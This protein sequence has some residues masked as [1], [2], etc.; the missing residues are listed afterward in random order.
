MPHELL[1]ADEIRRR[2]PMFNVSDEEFGYFE[3]SAGFVRPEACVHAQLELAKKYGAD[4]HMHENGHGLRCRMDGRVTVK[5]DTGSYQA[6][7]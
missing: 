6:E 3:P 1:D 7:G 5:T 2:Y 4:L